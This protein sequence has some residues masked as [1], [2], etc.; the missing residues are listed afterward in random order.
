MRKPYVEHGEQIIEGTILDDEVMNGIKET[1]AANLAA[2]MR[3]SATL[4]TQS[5]LA[6]RSRVAQTTIGNY[7]NPHSYKGAP[8]LDKLVRL[9][10]AFK[11]PVWA[12]L[13]PDLDPSSP[14]VILSRD[15][16]REYEVMKA[17]YK[18]VLAAAEGVDERAP[19]GSASGPVTSQDSGSQPKSAS[20]RRKRH[21]T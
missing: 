21:H 1:L 11:L 12:L 8:S 10:S 7:L 17:V 6:R 20:S 15:Q 16:R 19:S 4:R 13:V 18:Q 14:P 2:L 9:S 5:A 3:Q